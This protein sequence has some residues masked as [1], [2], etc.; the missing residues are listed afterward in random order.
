MHVEI[1]SFTPTFMGEA[2]NCA[3]LIWLNVKSEFTNALPWACD[4]FP[5]DFLCW[6]QFDDLHIHFVL[7]IWAEL[8]MDNPSY[9]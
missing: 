9:F 3:A 8:K 7:A 4:T 2:Q 1:I 6:D 5:N